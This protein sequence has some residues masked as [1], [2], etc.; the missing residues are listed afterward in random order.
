MACCAELM[1]RFLLRCR[2]AIISKEAMCPPASSANGY[3]A[4]C[5]RARQDS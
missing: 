3:P 4:A 1:V 2:L 5:D